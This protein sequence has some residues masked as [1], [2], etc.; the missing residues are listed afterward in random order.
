MA[1]W[2]RYS[3]KVEVNEYIIDELPPPDSSPD[4][5]MQLRAR[6]MNFES[7]NPP[8]IFLQLPRFNKYLENDITKFLPSIRI[9]NRQSLKQHSTNIT[10][11]TN[12]TTLLFQ[13]NMSPLYWTLPTHLLFV[14]EWKA[15]R[16]LASDLHHRRPIGRPFGRSSFNIPHL[17]SS[18]L[19]AEF[20]I[21]ETK[22]ITI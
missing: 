16:V 10:T 15:A 7:M 20:I 4:L 14:S 21:F 6:I 11:T 18:Q 13:C 1:H 17:K 3:D 12:T 22:V 19:T 8:E 2:W 5:G 9:C